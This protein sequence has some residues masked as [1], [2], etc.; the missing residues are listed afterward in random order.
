MNK[1]IDKFQEK[2]EIINS[3]FTI[4][5][6]GK[7]I[8]PQLAILGMPFIIV[9]HM[10][11]SITAK[12]FY[13]IFMYIYIFGVLRLAITVYKDKRAILYNII[14]FVLNIFLCGLCVEHKYY[15]GNI[16]T[17]FALGAVVQGPVLFLLISDV[18][19]FTK[20]SKKKAALDLDETE[21]IEH[22][23]RV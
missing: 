14:F 17:I 6:F 11:T 2:L 12:I 4:F 16:S 21:N 3:I 1:P 9:S 13:V 18:C 19:G 5:E 8:L 15:L 20:S 7:M 22:V 23:E 10:E